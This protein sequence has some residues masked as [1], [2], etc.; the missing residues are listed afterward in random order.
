M[1]V[2]FCSGVDEEP[3]PRVP[4]T[5]IIEVTVKGAKTPPTQTPTYHWS[6]ADIHAVVQ[7]YLYAHE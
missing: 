3:V 5:H 6:A 1:C 2:S 4:I 7:E